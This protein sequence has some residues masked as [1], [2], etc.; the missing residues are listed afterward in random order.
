MGAVEIVGV[1]AEVLADP[2]VQSAME[3]VTAGPE[4]QAGTTLTRA[5]QNGVERYGV[6]LRPISLTVVGPMMVQMTGFKPSFPEAYQMTAMLF[7]LGAPLKDVY[8]ALA[9]GEKEGT[10][11]FMAAAAEWVGKSGIPEDMSAETMEAVTQ[12]FSMASK[13]IGGGDDGGKKA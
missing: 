7:I 12:T 5:L 2:R 6:K 3:S 1:S 11:A 4:K 13:L 9:D 10:P 8:R